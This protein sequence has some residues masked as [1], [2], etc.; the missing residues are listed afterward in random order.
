VIAVLK[1]EPQAELQAL[2]D[3]LEPVA[4]ETPDVAAPTEAN[5]LP[6]SLDL[7]NKQ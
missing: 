5:V 3:E 6:Y 4:M 1:R 2:L 7:S